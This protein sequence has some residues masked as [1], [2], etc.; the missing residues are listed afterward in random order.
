MPECRDGQTTLTLVELDV[1]VLNWSVRVTSPV[2]RGATVAPPEQLIDVPARSFQSVFDNAVGGFASTG[3]H[4]RASL[5]PGARISGPAVVQERETTHCLDFSN[6]ST[7]ASG[8]WLFFATMPFLSTH[9]VTAASLAWI[10][11]RSTLPL[12][13]CDDDPSGIWRP[14]PL[15]GALGA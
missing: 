12:M 2:V 5:A 3:V 8:R 10:A 15:D 11:L 7:D 13:R 9:R 1:E 14:A 4:D 6:P